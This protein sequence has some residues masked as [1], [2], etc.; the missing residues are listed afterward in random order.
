MACHPVQCQL[1]SLQHCTATQ[2]DMSSDHLLISLLRDRSPLT[3]PDTTVVQ[4]HEC[5]VSRALSSDISLDVQQIISETESFQ[6][7]DCT[8]I[9][10]EFT[11]LLPNTH[12]QMQ[13]TS[14]LILR[15][16]GTCIYSCRTYALSVNW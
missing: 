15:L 3:I 12:C 6:A 11:E 5:R 1:D 10:N 8:D 2:S 7:A 16:N 4:V 14:T 9:D 13:Q